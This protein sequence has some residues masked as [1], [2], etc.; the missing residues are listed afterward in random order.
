MAWAWFG[1]LGNSLRLTP[2]ILA[3]VNPS[4]FPALLFLRG[5][6]DLQIGIMS[7]SLRTVVLTLAAL[8]IVR[9]PPQCWLPHLGPHLVMPTHQ[10]DCR[11]FGP[12]PPSPCRMGHPSSESW[13][14]S[15]ATLNP[16]AANPEVPNP[17]SASAKPNLNSR[18]M[19]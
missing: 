12:G 9:L 1:C 4:A 2:D 5:G 8:Y 17:V 14:K 11:A 3:C 16:K 19:V 6:P 10:Q 7:L 15:K 18:S 13:N